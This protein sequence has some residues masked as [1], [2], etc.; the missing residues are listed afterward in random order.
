MTEPEQQEECD[1][2]WV[3][4]QMGGSPDTAEAYEWIEYCDL[5]GMENPGSGVFP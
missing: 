4:R 2:V 1:H 3:G 5:C